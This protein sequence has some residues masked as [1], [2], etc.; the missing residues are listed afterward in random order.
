M[1]VNKY[2]RCIKRRILEGWD[3]GRKKETEAP[4]RDAS[5]MLTV[6]NELELTVYIILATIFAELLPPTDFLFGHL[7]RKQPQQPFRL[8]YCSRA[9]RYRRPQASG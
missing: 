3:G 2:C 6:K 5:Q 9:L 8:P 1:H 4:E 7:P